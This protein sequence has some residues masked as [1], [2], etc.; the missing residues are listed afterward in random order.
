MSGV[1]IRPLTID[2]KKRFLRVSIGTM[3]ENER[4]VTTFEEVVNEIP[5]LDE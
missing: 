4:F 5:P 3:E 1:I 2:G